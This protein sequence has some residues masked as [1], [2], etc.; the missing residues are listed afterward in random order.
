MTKGRNGGKIGEPA[1]EKALETSEKRSFEKN[2]KKVS[3]STW[4]SETQVI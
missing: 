4:Q 2:N 3:K 1:R